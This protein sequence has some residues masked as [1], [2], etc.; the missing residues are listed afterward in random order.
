MRALLRLSAMAL[1]VGLCL[2]VPPNAGAQSEWSPVFRENFATS[3]ARGQFPGPAYHG[4]FAQYDGFADSSG[5]G[6]YAPARVVSV[7]DGVLDLYLHSEGGR[8]LGAAAVPLIGGSWG[9]QTYGRYSVRFKADALPGF[10]AGWLL[11]P[12]S[13]NWNDGEINFPEG[14]LD[15]TMHG[16]VHCPG[17]PSRNCQVTNTGVRFSSG[18]HTAVIEWTPG[19]VKFVLDSAVVGVSPISPWKPLHWVLQ[20]ATTGVRPDADVKGHVLI[21]WVSVERLA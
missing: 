21:D 13:N 16:Y 20:T 2:S 10:G 1:I 11:W 7:H 18:W 9:G 6:L 19:Q 12:D 14:G 8:A 4:Q 3:V 17:D 5:V 15:E